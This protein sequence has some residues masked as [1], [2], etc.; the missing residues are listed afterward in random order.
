MIMLIAC[1]AKTT[2]VQ[3]RKSPKVRATYIRPHYVN[4]RL[5]CMASD[6]IIVACIR[7]VEKAGLID[8]GFL[9]T[10]VFP[11]VEM[12][13]KGIGQVTCQ[14]CV[15]GINGGLRLSKCG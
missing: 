14:P 6:P 3:I 2:V 8:S 13:V 10:E 12:L 11:T 5:L 1:R 7:L 4:H 15:I 9:K